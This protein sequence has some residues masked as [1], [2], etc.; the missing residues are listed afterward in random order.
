VKNRKK[1]NENR[2]AKE[3][4]ILLTL[5]K[6]II[7]FRGV[8]GGRVIFGG[9]QMEMEYIKLFCI[10]GLAVLAFAYVCWKTKFHQEKPFV[11]YRKE[12]SMESFETW[13]Q[14]HHKS[15]THHS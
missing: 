15:A 8:V 2:G 12:K 11:G 4:F 1:K 5:A 13:L 7:Y 3:N 14:E 10:A 9:I 6:R